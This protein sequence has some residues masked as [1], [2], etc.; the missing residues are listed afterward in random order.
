MTPQPKPGRTRRTMS[1]AAFARLAGVS[2]MAISKAARKA[3]KAACV[4]DRIDAAHPAAV[5][6]LAAK[7]AQRPGASAAAAATATADALGDTLEADL[8]R[9]YGELTLT[10]IIER[11]GTLR[12]LRDLLDARKKIEDIIKAETDNRRLEGELIERELVAVHVF[13]VLESLHRRLLVD[14]PRTMV[15]RLYA[16]ARNGTPS[17]EAENIIRDLI[18]GQLKPATAS[19][20]RTLKRVA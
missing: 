3:L 20:T 8:L 2:A 1:R 12:E 13:G 17:E 15:S 19:V 6:Y 18:S 10:E 16:A 9:R 14:L 4:G 11:H 7:P 5:A